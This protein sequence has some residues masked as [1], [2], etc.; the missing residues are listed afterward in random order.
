MESDSHSKTALSACHPAKIRGERE[1]QLNEQ[2]KFNVLFL[3]LLV[4]DT[5]LVILEPTISPSTILVVGGNTI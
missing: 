4:S 3:L 1:C 2:P 5:H